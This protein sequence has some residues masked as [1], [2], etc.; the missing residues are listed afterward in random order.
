MI[1]FVPPLITSEK[2]AFLLKMLLKSMKLI[3]IFFIRVVLPRWAEHRV[4][5]H[6]LVVLWLYLCS[7]K[8]HN[9]IS[10]FKYYK[11]SDELITF[12]TPLAKENL[13]LHSYAILDYSIF[14]MEA[15]HVHGEVIQTLWR[16]KNENTNHV[17]PPY[18]PWS[19]CSEVSNF[20]YLVF[21]LSTIPLNSK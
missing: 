16:A 17:F 20:Y 11:I 7:S 2:L 1:D 8:N 9:L 14:K 15:I 3:V 19:C 4:K 12:H 6:V 10:N 5:C 18:R 13:I 21:L